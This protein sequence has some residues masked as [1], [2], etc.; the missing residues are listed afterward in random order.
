ME[1]VRAW[2]IHLGAHKT[3]TTHLQDTLA[4][5]R[6]AMLGCGVDFL[7]R[8]RTRPILRRFARAGGWR[9]R[10]W[11]PPLRAWFDHRLAAERRGPDTV[12]LSEEDLLGFTTDLLRAPV[13]GGSDALH[14]VAHLAAG[15]ETTL[16]LGI[17]S[18]DAILPSA[19]AQ[20]L[21]ALP[22]PAGG[23][24]AIRRRIAQAPPSWLD[25]VDRI[26]HAVPGAT[27]HVWRHEDYRAHW[28]VLL[29]GFAGREIG[30][31]PDLPPPPGTL[32][33]APEAVAEAEALDPGLSQPARIAAVNRIYAARPAS[34][35]GGRYAPLSPAEIAALRDRYA[36]DLDTLA[37][38]H[39]GMLLTPG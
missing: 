35:A 19:Y 10:L 7:P 2:R 32:S 16:F 33:P 30:P 37:A 24:E 15:R 36:R 29:A 12:L 20:A 23:M 34:G 1:P 3:A 25:L 28:R 6:D 18:F 13:Y 26:R 21:R 39:P 31:L 5:H 38:R 11:S 8:D 4:A 17:R 27:L 22:P 14:L 9:R